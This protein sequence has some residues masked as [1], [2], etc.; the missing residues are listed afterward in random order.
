MSKKS[1]STSN[2][3]S[4]KIAAGGDVPQTDIS[5]QAR[6]EIVMA[7]PVKHGPTWYRPGAKIVVTAAILSALG[8]AVASKTEV[9]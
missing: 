2:A 8:D 1:T 9:K 7:R 3:E 5:N 4:K 6:Y